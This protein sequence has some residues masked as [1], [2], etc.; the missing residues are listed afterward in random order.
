MRSPFLT[1]L[2][3]LVVACDLLQ[4]PVLPEG[5]GRRRRGSSEGEDEGEEGANFTAVCLR[6]AE[7]REEANPAQFCADQQADCDADPE[8]RAQRATCVAETNA[9]VECL[10][11]NGSCDQIPGVDGAFFGFDAMSEGAACERLA[12]A[13]SACANGGEGEGG[14]GIDDFV[15]DDG[16]CIPNDFLCDGFE[17]CDDGRDEAPVNPAC[18]PPPAP[19]AEW[20]CD[21]EFFNDG[22]CDCGCG[23]P[24][25]DCGATPTL[26]RCEFCDG[27][28]TT[29]DCPGTIDPSDI[30]QCS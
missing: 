22:S 29:A 25:P 10:L 14:C 17:D 18:T 24:D 8:C 4:P 19:P 6:S 13:Q 23:F 2:A 21:D 9:L 30:T 11:A 7:C 15:C 26:A 28:S 1:L 12:A 5:E 3:L 20:I 16:T 27:C